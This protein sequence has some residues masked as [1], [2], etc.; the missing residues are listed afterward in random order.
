MVTSIK[1]TTAWLWQAYYGHYRHCYSGP[2]DKLLPHAEGAEIANEN[3][4]QFVWFHMPKPADKI[5]NTE[6]D[7][8]ADVEKQDF[9]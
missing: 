8:E 6:P 2:S 9:S 5:R 1:G 7:H 3:E 4:L